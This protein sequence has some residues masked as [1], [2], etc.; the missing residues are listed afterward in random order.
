MSLRKAVLAVA[1]CLLEAGGIPLQ[2]NTDETLV[3]GAV[4]LHPRKAQ[5]IIAD[6]ALVVGFLGRFQRAGQIDGQRIVQLGLRLFRS[7]R[8]G[9]GRFIRPVSAS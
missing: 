2:I 4:L 5:R 3:L 8:G 9:A 7:L 1:L 6:V